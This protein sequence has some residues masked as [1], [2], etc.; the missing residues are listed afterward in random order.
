MEINGL[1]V[2]RCL[3]R[4]GV[5]VVGIHAPQTSTTVTTRYAGR[6][7][8]C[9]L[10]DRAA[11]L[12]QL[13][14]LADEL[15]EPPALF[16]TSDEQVRLL[17]EKAD[18]L[19]PRYEY[20]MPPPAQVRMLQNKTA[21]E[22]AARRGGFPVPASATVS[23][24]AK[25]ELAAQGIGFP[26]VVKPLRKS[27]EFTEAFRAK[28]LLCHDKGEVGRIL[29]HPL[30]KHDAFLVQEYV[31]G[32]DHDVYFVLHYF[33][34]ES[35]PLVSFAGRKIRQTPPVFGHTA[36][37]E[38]VEQA[39]LVAISESFFHS[40]GFCGL[41]SMEFK[42]DPRDGRF[43]MIE[44]TIGRTD[45]QSAVAHVNR[46]PIVEIAYCDALGLPHPAVSPSRSRRKWVEFEGDLRTAL[47]ERRQGA[48]SWGGW[49]R[50]IWPFR[51]A[52]A[53][54]DDPRPALAF[55]WQVCKRIVRKVARRRGPRRAARARTSGTRR[56]K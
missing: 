38:P 33:D 26:C 24:P 1:G 20:V 52:V 23:D 6:K 14:R 40:V 17:S 56:S 46:V 21:F 22:D 29:S 44:P 48:L 49:L 45:W 43:L 42:R 15:D 16:A 30:C 32:T 47:H 12:N 28:A 36:S 34:R 35:T 7:I 37:A 39:D 13:L 51:P 19:R 41:G 8:P 4:A 18:E 5:S 2:I 31:P 10:R 3:G 53:A 9:D 11:L 54:L 55:A 25:A 27:P 50:S